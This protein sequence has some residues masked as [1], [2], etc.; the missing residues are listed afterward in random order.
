MFAPNATSSIVAVEEARCRRSRAVD[1]LVRASRGLERAAEVRVRVA[2]VAR[3]CL[4]HRVGHLRPAG[5]VEERERL[6][7]RGEPRANRV[8]RRRR[9]ALSPAQRGRYLGPSGPGPRVAGMRLRT[10]TEAECYA[11]IYGGHG[12]ER[13]SFVRLLPRRGKRSSAVGRAPAWK[14]RGAPRPARA[15]GGSGMT[16]TCRTWNARRL[17]KQV[18]AGRRPAPPLPEL[19]GMHGHLDAA[20]ATLSA[21]WQES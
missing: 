13:V 16:R 7:E 20:R 2:Q 12:D 18:S 3:D 21:A 15:R 4:D 10:L 14:V 1:E 11:R 6:L 17:P 5:P 9:R 8:D 19:V